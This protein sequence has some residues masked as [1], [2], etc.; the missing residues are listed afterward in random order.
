MLSI[1]WCIGLTWLSSSHP[2]FWDSIQLGSKHAHHYFEGNFSSFLLPEAIDSGHPP[3]FGMYLAAFWLFFGKTLAVSHWSMLPIL[4]ILVVQWFNLGKRLVGKSLLPYFMLFL[5]IDPVI[6]SQAS[7]VSPDLALAACFLLLVN[8]VYEGN[9]NWH[10]LAVMGLGMISTRGMMVALLVFIWQYLFIS[11]RT[12][13]QS[14]LT[15]LLDILYPY[16]PGGILAA[17]YLV[18]HYWSTGWIGYHAN[19]EWAP[20]F[21]FADVRQVLKNG[22]VLIWR[23]LDFGRLFLVGGILFTTWVLWN[24]KSLKKGLFDPQLKKISAL[25][26]ILLGGLGFSFLIYAGLQQ[27]RYLLP[28]YLS[29]TLLFFLCIKE[30]SSDS[31]TPKLKSL[32]LGVVAI[33]LLTGNLWIYPDRIS[34]GWDST[35]AHWPFFELRM[36][37][38][39][40]IDTAEIPLEEIGTAFPE[41]GPIK[42]K[43]LSENLSGFKA[44]DL[45]TDNFVLYSNI[46]ND[47]TDTELWRLEEEWEVLHEIRRRGIKM[48]LYR[49]PE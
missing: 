24:N 8:T 43:D 7:L 20:S 26:V 4:L 39:E 13:S 41:I 11:R 22:I 19:S 42:F 16:L 1:I 30:L 25:L 35:L 12:A 23:L 15:H 27:H 37:M 34:Q 2:F 40:Y 36:Q 46:M 49:R 9:K 32:F 29:L 14:R 6:A 44:K 28:V 10:I 38:L 31:W 33:G 48:I 17:I 3:Y 18:Y 5:V 21:A 47:F 45:R